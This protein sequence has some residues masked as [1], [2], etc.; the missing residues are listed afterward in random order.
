MKEATKEKVNGV[1]EDI[2]KGSSIL[3][4]L[5][6]SQIILGFIPR[7]ITKISLLDKLIPFTGAM[8]IGVSTV[9]LS[10]NKYV[11]SAGFGVIASGVASAFNRLTEGSTNKVA[12]KINEATNLPTVSLNGLGNLPMLTQGDS[13]FLSGGLKAAPAALPMFADSPFAS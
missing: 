3:G 7:E 2:G 8:A 11:K 10:K 6:L 5:M 12:Q 1:V 13:A 9:G 4:G